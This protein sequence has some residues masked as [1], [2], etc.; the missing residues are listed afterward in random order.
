MES[1]K[2]IPPNQS[3][4]GFDHIDI[5][6]SE[7]ENE[8]PGVVSCVDLLVIAALESLIFAGGPFYP[9]HTGRKDSDHSFPQLSYELP[10]PFDDLPTN[11][12]RFATSMW[13]K[14]YGLES[15][16][17]KYGRAREAG[18]ISKS[19]LTLGRIINALVEHS[20]HVPSRDSKLTRLLRYSLG[21]KTKSCIIAM[22]SPSTH[23]LEE[24]L[25]T[26]GYAHR[27]KSI[28]NKPEKYDT[29]GDIICHGKDKGIKEGH[30]NVDDDAT[31][32]GLH[33]SFLNSI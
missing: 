33:L 1:E 17:V 18:E 12:A 31:G 8:C 5:I 11:I 13:L 28:K 32:F 20:G 3:L 21:G 14:E 19:L 29:F 30:K 25:N 22:V 4:K 7:L 26:L 10:S 2:D 16:L 24:T 27:A 9:V 15:E 23:C 6:K